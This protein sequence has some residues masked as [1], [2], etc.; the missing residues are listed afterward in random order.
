VAARGR[1]RT[2]T[3]S[4]RE[5]WGKCWRGRSWRYFWCYG[6]SDGRR[7]WYHRAADH[8]TI[9]GS[10]TKTMELRQSPVSHRK[11]GVSRDHGATLYPGVGTTHSSSTIA[12]LVP[13]PR[14]PPTQAARTGSPARSDGAQGMG[15]GA[16]SRPIAE[17]DGGQAARRRRPAH[18]VRGGDRRRQRQRN[19][20]ASPSAATT[21]IPRSGT[22][23]RSEARGGYS[24]LVPSGR[25]ARWKRPSST[26]RSTRTTNRPARAA[27]TPAAPAGSQ[28]G[29]EAMAGESAGATEV[30]VVIDNEVRATKDEA[31]CHKE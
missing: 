28:G 3:R 14:Q 16:P 9:R 13:S 17:R 26:T 1:R 6:G 10:S 5:A 24:R 31:A 8:S 20:R 11:T 30:Y 23:R 15:R 21:T 12:A 27:T 7:A 4:P 22:A 2:T 18:R 29:D 19:P 25:A